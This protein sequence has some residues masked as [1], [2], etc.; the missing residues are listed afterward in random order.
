M[1]IQQIKMAYE[2]SFKMRDRAETKR[3]ILHDS[4][5]T[6]D[7]ESR[8]GK[9][10]LAAFKEGALNIEY[11]FVITTDGSIFET[12]PMDSV[13]NHTPGHNLDSI[14][15]CLM[16]GRKM[17]YTADRKYMIARPADTFTTEQKASLRWLIDH[18]K[19][20]YGGHLE[21]FGQSEVQTFVGRWKGVQEPPM[22]LTK[23]R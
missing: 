1:V 18:L 16:G 17:V 22:D 4:H 3:I 6:P 23:F 10:L 14:G 12:R 11:H 13:G 9:L 5:S 15:V 20:H 8:L 7:S 2:G 21:V 19:D